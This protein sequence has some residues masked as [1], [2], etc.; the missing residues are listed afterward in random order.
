MTRNNLISLIVLDVI[1]MIMALGLMAYRYQAITSV[2]ISSM[3]QNLKTQA[4]AAPIAQPQHQDKVETAKVPDEEKQAKAETTAPAATRNISF[5]YKNSK[6]KK[7]EVIG[8][9]TDWVPK[10]MVSSG[11][12]TW[13]LTVQLAPGDY[14]YN[15]VVNGKPRRDP[16]NP[17]VCNAGRGFTNS[18]L[19]VKP[20]TNENTKAD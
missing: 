12:N 8:D 17:K 3:K 11:A 20:L 19:K 10:K 7:V 9:F 2:P 14:A 18:F 16:N 1:V 13:K 15:Y 5:T 4:E 6:A